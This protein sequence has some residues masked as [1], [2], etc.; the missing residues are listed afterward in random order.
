MIK[1]VYSW[2]PVYNFIMDIVDKANEA[3]IKIDG[4]IL[5]KEV[6]NIVG[7]EEQKK[8]AS[9]LQ[10]NQNGNL[11]LVRYGN[12]SN[13]FS[14]EI[15]INMDNM[16]DIFG[17]FY[18]ECRS[19]VVD[20]AN[21][22]IVLC[23]FKKFRN[24]NEGEENSLKNIQKRI[25]ECKSFEISDKLDGSMQSA[26][27]YEDRVVM[28]GSQAIDMN[29]SWRLKD[30]YEKLMSQK[31]YVKMLKNHPGFTF[32]FE[33]I[34]LEDA[35]VVKYTKEQEGLYLIGI[36]CNLNGKQSSYKEVVD[37][38]DIYGIKTT[39]IFDKTLDDILKDIKVYSSDKKEGFVLNI[40]GY[41]VKVK[42]DDYVQ[43]HKSIS[44]LSSTNGIIKAVADDNFD[45]FISKIPEAYR[46]RVVN[47]ANKVYRYI[48]FTDLKVNLFFNECNQ[49]S[50]DKKEFM[51]CV[52][53]RV[54]RDLQGYVRNMY[55]GKK[56]NYIKTDGKCPHYKNM[57]EMG[58]N[59][60][61]E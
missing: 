44:S 30:G 1:T 11:L 61:N 59:D 35:H 46:D 57:N 19:L 34:S 47:V 55:F 20:L 22:I 8:I 9:I 54:P 23:P 45:D 7:S 5:F 26:T 38:A 49:N 3:K 33:Y 12:Y 51:S 42:C 39:K 53:K 36:R 52:D 43:V 4:S 10:F 32:I 2:N 14:G 16:W 58:L 15:D 41:M 40:D 28:S 21:K 48:Y 27:W 13:I 29:D 6:V 50:K 24:L 18:K 56:N 37:I 17:G 60:E 31:N 25:S